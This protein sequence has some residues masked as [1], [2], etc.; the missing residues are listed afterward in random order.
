MSWD[1]ILHREAAED[2]ARNGNL[3]S[4]T[5]FNTR[6]RGKTERSTVSTYL[7]KLQKS[8]QMK[9]DS[10]TR[11]KKLENKPVLPTSKN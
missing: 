1:V 11:T 6:F 7:T 8:Q 5:Y 2:S 3:V 9:L 4:P 10:S